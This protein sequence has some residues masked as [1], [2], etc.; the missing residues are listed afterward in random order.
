MPPLRI[1]NFQDGVRWS[2]VI[3]ACFQRMAVWA[4]WRRALRSQPNTQLFDRT[5]GETPER[6]N[7]NPRPNGFSVSAIPSFGRLGVAGLSSTYYWD[8]GSND[9]PSLTVTGVA[10]SGV[11]NNSA[12]FPLLGLLGRLGLRAGPVFLANGMTAKDTLGRGSTISQSTMIPSVTLNTTR[13][14]FRITSIEGGISSNMGQYR[15][16]TY[17]VS[18]QQIGDAIVT[19]AMGPEDELPPF[20]R[21]LQSGVGTIGENNAARSDWWPSWRDRRAR[22][23]GACRRIRGNV[24]RSWRLPRRPSHQQY[25]THPENWTVDAAGAIVPALVDSSPS[26]ANAQIRRRP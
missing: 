1:I 8:P 26:T 15:A 24:G 22:Y 17:T 13:G 16:P 4:K 6:Q 11:D 19:P 2:R 18:G 10:G 25:P 14:P 9:S 21:A 3:C 20:V 5:G 23:P 12:G 7:G